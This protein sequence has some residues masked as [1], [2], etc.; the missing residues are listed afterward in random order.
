MEQTR[1]R[2][3]YAQPAAVQ[4]N[5][6]LIIHLGC[7]RHWQYTKRF[8]QLP[9]VAATLILV[10]FSAAVFLPRKAG[11]LTS[12]TAGKSVMFDSMLSSNLPKT[13]AKKKKGKDTSPRPNLWA[14]PRYREE[15]A[16]G[17][18]EKLAERYA[19]TE[20]AA[21]SS[22]PNNPGPRTTG[23]LTIS[24]PSSS[25][26]TLRLRSSD[27]SEQ[28][29]RIRPGTETSAEIPSGKYTYELIGEDIT[30]SGSTGDATVHKG[31]DQKLTVE[32]SDGS[33]KLRN[34]NR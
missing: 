15:P 22:D 31:K 4:L 1:P 21:Q 9:Y 23:N 8:N 3:L 24:N 26:R 18:T 25:Q 29:V 19:R 16:D 34:P 10:I 12:K 20:A 14:V 7:D 6:P 28:V 2:G 11:T 30:E 17:I 33:V 13:G 5:G 27:S 32:S